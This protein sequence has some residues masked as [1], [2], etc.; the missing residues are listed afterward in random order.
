M[1]WSKQRLG[2]NISSHVFGPDV[3]RLNL[4]QFIGLAHKIMVDVYMLSP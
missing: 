1:F 2:E 4:L 3:L